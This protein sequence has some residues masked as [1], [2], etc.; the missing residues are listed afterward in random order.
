MTNATRQALER[1]D[2]ILHEA[3]WDEPAVPDEP[4]LTAADTELDRI[5]EILTATLEKGLSV[6]QAGS[7]MGYGEKQARKVFLESL[8]RLAD[9]VYTFAMHERMPG[10]GIMVPSGDPGERVTID[11]DAKVPEP[12]KKVPSGDLSHSS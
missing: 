10:P 9:L 6:K 5:L 4:R 3:G 12:G 7:G 2:Q 8:E 1:A 11:A